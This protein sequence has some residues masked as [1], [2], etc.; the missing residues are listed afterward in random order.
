MW[1]RVREEVVLLVKQA[2][3]H[4]AEQSE[5]VKVIKSTVCCTVMRQD[6]NINSAFCSGLQIV[7]NV[8]AQQSKNTPP[9][10]AD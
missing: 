2:V 7:Q 3:Y 8:R 6:Y 4:V 1:E 5:T 10:E 9:D